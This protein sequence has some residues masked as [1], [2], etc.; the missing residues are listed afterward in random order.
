MK[1]VISIAVIAAALVVPSA[2]S[3]HQFT[4]QRQCGQPAFGLP[5]ASGLSANEAIWF[6]AGIYRQMHPTAWKLNK[7]VAHHRLSPNALWVKAYGTTNDNCKISIVRF[8][9]YV[10]KAECY[11]GDTGPQP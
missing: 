9:V 4:T 11:F 3:A 10:Y 5:C 8:G 1:K 6:E 7:L 2:A